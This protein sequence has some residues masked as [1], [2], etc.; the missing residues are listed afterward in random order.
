MSIFYDVITTG[1]SEF[2]KVSQDRRHS[3]IAPI[4]RRP[5]KRL[6][7]L[8]PTYSYSARVSPRHTPKSRY[9][10][11]PCNKTLQEKFLHTRR[12]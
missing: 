9:S 11:N 5:R 2:L 1:S 8:H 4:G 12:H 3:A 6:G 7:M 10:K